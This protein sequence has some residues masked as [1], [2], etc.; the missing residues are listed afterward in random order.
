MKVTRIKYGETIEVKVKR[1]V[2]NKL[3]K[4]KSNNEKV[5]NKSM[6]EVNSLIY[7]RY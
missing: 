1:K 4:N 7:V 3:M 6:N 5:I 2:V